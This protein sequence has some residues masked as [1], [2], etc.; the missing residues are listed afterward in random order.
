MPL[1]D[2]RPALAHRPPPA[3]RA[4]PRRGP[5]LPLLYRTRPLGGDAR[6]P[7]RRRPRP[8]GPRPEPRRAPRPDRQHGP[9]FLAPGDRPDVPRLPARPDHPRE[10]SATSTTAPTA[11]ATAPAWDR[12]VWAKTR[13]EAVFLTN[14]FDDPLEGWD[15]AQVRPLP[16]D[17]RPGPEAPRA[18]DRRAAAGARRASTCRTTP[19]S[20]RRSA[21][22]S[23]GS[24][25][26]GRGPARSAC[27]P[28]SPRTG[29]R[30]KRAVTPIRRAL[31]QMDLRPDEH[32]EIRRVV[33]WTLAEFC[34]EFTAAVRP[35]D[36]PD[37]QRLPG[38][39]RRG[40]RPVRPPGEPA[41]LP[42][43]VQPLLRA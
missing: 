27:R 32:D 24:W 29:R 35:D 2:L 40:P 38:G 14:D 9:V 22:S 16:A 15:T 39:G 43:A 8:R 26:R 33:F 13:L 36:R 12:E 25:R 4:E 20:G 28:T 41:R 3:R 1:A 30:P 23:S 21:C 19:R 6:R 42:R 11:S 5:G 34:A 7:G 37:P 31:H 17:R 10:R 18:D